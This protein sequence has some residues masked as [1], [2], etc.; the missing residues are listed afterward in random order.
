MVKCAVWGVTAD[1][2]ELLWD[3]SRVP[4]CSGWRC[5]SVDTAVSTV[6]SRCS[7]MEINCESIISLVSC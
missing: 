2:R 4:S 3:Y 7:D 6:E 5:C 1:A